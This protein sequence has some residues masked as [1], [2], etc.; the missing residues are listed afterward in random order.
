[1]NSLS[2]DEVVVK[3]I[4][5]DSVRPS[6]ICEVVKSV[7]KKKYDGHNRAK[8]AIIEACILASRVKLLKKKKDIR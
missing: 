7:L 8:A 1:M 6:F 4:I 5:E 2:Y 3:K